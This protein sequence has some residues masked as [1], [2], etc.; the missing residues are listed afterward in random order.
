MT[1]SARRP[2]RRAPPVPW[3][4]R[5]RRRPRWPSGRRARSAIAD[6]DG[7]DDETARTLLGAPP[8]A[9]RDAVRLALDTADARPFP[10]ALVDRP[11]VLAR[12]REPAGRLVSVAMQRAGGAA[13]RGPL[14]H[15]VGTVRARLVG[16]FTPATADSLVRRLVP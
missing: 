10:G 1:S 6:A 16:E 4:P 15:T 13:E 8:L 14:W 5:R 11:L 3:P 12:W 9:L 2:S 7:I